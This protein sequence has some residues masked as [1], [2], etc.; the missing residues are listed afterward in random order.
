MSTDLY[1]VR[2]L[3][4][5]GKCLTCRVT[6]FYPRSE[7]DPLPSRTLALQFLWEP[8]LWFSEGLSCN[9]T[10]GAITVKRAEELGRTAPIGREL[11]SRGIC[12]GDWTRANVGRFISHVEVQD[13][14]WLLGD[15]WSD[16]DEQLTQEPAPE[17]VVVGLPET[18]VTFVVTATDP[19]WLAHLRPGMEWG[20]TAYDKD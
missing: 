20:S 11:V 13:R 7:N 18:Q 6:A 9:M 15:R 5:A 8:W 14:R 12:D 2:V 17:G 16:V 4:V 3:S 1:Q 10:G 19:R